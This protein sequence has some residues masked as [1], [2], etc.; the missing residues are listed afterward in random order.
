MIGLDIWIIGSLSHQISHYIQMTIPAARD[1]V[2][3]HCHACWKVGKMIIF[4]S[5]YGVH[6]RG[7]R[8]HVLN[9]T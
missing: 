9:C 6:V 7:L 2:Y 5:L 8:A 4:C 1:V 3:T